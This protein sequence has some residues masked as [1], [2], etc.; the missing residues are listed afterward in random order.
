MKLGESQISIPM[1]VQCVT[2]PSNCNSVHY[3][4]SY[5]AD[6][7]HMHYTLHRQRYIGLITF[8]HYFTRVSIHDKMVM[9]RANKLVTICESVKH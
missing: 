4:Y 3:S 6:R 8:D 1:Q 7:I 9:G 2:S 5:A